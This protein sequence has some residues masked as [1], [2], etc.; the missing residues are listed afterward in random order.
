MREITST[1]TNS[2]AG[3][4]GWTHEAPS[5]TIDWYTPDY[6]F[7]ALAVTFDLDPCSP[8]SSRSNVP[9]GAV[10]TLADDGLSSPW[11]GL[12]WV[13]PP[14]DDTRTWLQRLADHGEGIALVFARTDTKWFHEAAKSADLVCFTSGRIKFIDGR[15]MQPGGSPGAGSVFLAWGATAAAALGASG[16][17]LCFHLD[18]ISG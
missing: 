13:N 18:S 9:A 16:L 17:G 11:R 7:Q 5:A 12:C 4:G 14:Y 2:R 1:T 8:G 3:R 15:T 10:Y 6:I